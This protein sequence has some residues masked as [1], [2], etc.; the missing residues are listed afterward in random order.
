MEVWTRTGWI[1]SPEMGFQEDYNYTFDIT[2]VV[3]QVGVKNIQAINGNG[4]LYTS[5]ELLGVNLENYV[6][7]M[8]TIVD[9]PS[10]RGDTGQSGEGVQQLKTVYQDAS[11]RTYENSEIIETEG[12]PSCAKCAEVRGG[13]QPIQKMYQKAWVNECPGCETKGKLKAVTKSSGD[14]PHGVTVCESCGLKYCQFCG[15]DRDTGNYQLTELFKHQETVSDTLNSTS[16]DGTNNT[17]NTNGTTT[18]TNATTTTETQ[19]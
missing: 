10:E 17:N 7:R 4:E 1:I 18:P 8:G 11:G 12:E 9:N 19:S 6:G 5:E 3:T 14:D 15:Y 13:F 16:T 2:N